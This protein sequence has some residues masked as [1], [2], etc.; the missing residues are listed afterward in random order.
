MTAAAAFRRHAAR[1]GAWMGAWSLAAGLVLGAASAEAASC[2]VSDRPVSVD[3]TTR[4]D[5]ARVDHTKSREDIDRL[6]QETHGRATIPMNGGAV[7]LTVTRSEFR[8]NARTRISPQRDGTYCVYLRTVE[9]QMNQVNTVVY[10]NR[11]YPKGSCNYRVTYEH[12]K[13]HVGVYY[14]TQKDYAPRVKHA[15][16]RL[17]RS[18]NPRAAS[19]L[20]AARSLHAKAI[21]AGIADLLAEL[22]AERRRR[23]AALDT[24]ENYAR[25][26]A[27][28]P[29]W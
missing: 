8:F 11:D 28:C 6:F 18:V 12:E 1:L 24:P 3:L 17:V 4:F 16:E 22:E 2:P 20:E 27:K 7:G 26:R 10:I 5:T 23:N 13:M 9:A 15:L 25:E 21:N 19:S 14:F 29:T